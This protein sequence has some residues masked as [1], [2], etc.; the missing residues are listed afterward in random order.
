MMYKPSFSSS[1]FPTSYLVAPNLNPEFPPEVM[2]LVQQKTFHQKTKEIMFEYQIQ[3]F[4]NFGGL[5][6]KPW[7]VHPD[8]PFIHSIKFEFVEQ[9]DEEDKLEEEKSEEGDN[10]SEV[11]WTAHNF[12]I[13]TLISKRE[14]FGI[15]TIPYE[16]FTL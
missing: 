11:L 13:P 12:F 3:I 10:Y 7:G 4:K 14:S 1:T 9:P 16:L 8:Y 2:T 15:S 5:I 6:L